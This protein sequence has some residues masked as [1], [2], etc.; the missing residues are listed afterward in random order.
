MSKRPSGK[1]ISRNNLDRQNDPN[2]DRND[3]RLRDLK[4]LSI[5]KLECKKRG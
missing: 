1:K 3:D 2:D 5:N 4:F